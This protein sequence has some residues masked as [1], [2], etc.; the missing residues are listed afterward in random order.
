VQEYA[1]KLTLLAAAGMKLASELSKLG[2]LYKNPYGDA[3]ARLGQQ[4]TDVEALRNGLAANIAQRFVEP[5][6]K[7]LANEKDKFNNNEKKVTKTIQTYEA[8]LQQMTHQLAKDQS[9][10]TGRIIENIAAITKKVQ[11]FDGVNSEMLRDL[12]Q[13]Q[14]KQFIEWSE[15]WHLAV[16]AQLDYHVS[17]EKKLGALAPLWQID[18]AAAAA[19][20]AALTSS[21]SSTASAGAAAAAAAAADESKPSSAAPAPKKKDKK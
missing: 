7:S 8:T 20:P 14:Q 11:E 5:M 16:A 6:T 18:T 2:A 1:D 17:V 9:C 21:A 15:K 4:L 19:A 13:S 12:Q 3:L 10:G